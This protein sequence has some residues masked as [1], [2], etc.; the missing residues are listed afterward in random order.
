MN[1]NLTRHLC[2]FLGNVWYRI[3][4]CQ[5]ELSTPQTQILNNIANKG[6]RDT[7]KFII[8]K[9]KNVLRPEVQFRVKRVW[10]YIAEA[11]MCSLPASFVESFPSPNSH[12]C[13]EQGVKC[14]HPNPSKRSASA[15]SW[16]VW[17]VNKSFAWKKLPGSHVLKKWISYKRWA[18][19]NAFYK[20]RK[21]LFFGLNSSLNAEGVSGGFL[22]K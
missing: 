6:P 9:V 4:V 22:E 20:Y 15:A 14:S 11:K 1:R 8:L 12:W 10:L 16:Q 21:T 3:T 13:V 17:E 7:R 18:Q 2:D 19:I 5:A